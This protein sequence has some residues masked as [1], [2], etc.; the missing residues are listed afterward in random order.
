MPLQYIFTNMFSK[1]LSAK[2][3]FFL[4]MPRETLLIIW[5]LWCNTANVPH[6]IHDHMFCTWKNIIILLFGSCLEL[7]KLSNHFI[8]YLTCF[9]LPPPT[10][11]HPPT[12]THTPTQKEGPVNFAFSSSSCSFLN[13]EYTSKFHNTIRNNSWLPDWHVIFLIVFFDLLLTFHFIPG[14]FSD[15]VWSS[16]VV[17][18]IRGF[19]T[20]FVAKGICTSEGV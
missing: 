12:H 20:G 14:I 9:E 11:T 7:C 16:Q 1:L 5:E 13:G 19:F 10:P 18:D 6:A 8:I 15:L 17:I 4:I 3:G 2:Y